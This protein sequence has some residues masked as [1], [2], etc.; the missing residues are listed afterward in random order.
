M[1]SPSLATSTTSAQ[2]HLAD[3]PTAALS[4]F[5]RSRSSYIE[6][7]HDLDFAV[8]SLV[9]D[10]SFDSESW[11]LERLQH[12]NQQLW[13]LAS[14][15]DVEYRCPGIG[16]MYASWYHLR[17][18]RGAFEILRPRLAATGPITVL[19]LGCGTGAVAWAL[20]M[21]GLPVRY[22]GVD[23]SAP[24][25]AWAKGLW[26]TF[27][28]TLP[29]CDTVEVNWIEGDAISLVLDGSLG[30]EADVAVMP[31]LVDRSF[32][33]R[34]RSRG[35]AWRSCLEHMGVADVISW[36][37]ADKLAISLDLMK[38]TMGSAGLPAHPCSGYRFDPP[39]PLL[40]E[41]RLELTARLGLTLRDKQP[42]GVGIRDTFGHHFLVARKPR[43]RNS[44]SVVA[45]RLAL[46]PPQLRAT[47][48]AIGF[49]GANALTMA[50]P[51]T[52]GQLESIHRHLG[53][54][55]KLKEYAR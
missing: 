34:L 17:R 46:R 48:E 9:T 23:A 16:R 7:H 26:D 43:P 44:L 21:L 4:G 18:V 50:S 25:L 29:E 12:A 45:R 55:F 53:R 24:M 41:A 51:L 36:T 8:A 10:D 5:I 14:G 3:R 31:F 27:R 19:D 42:V 49:E 20:G 11:S 2:K 30:E 15:G 33:R 38:Q 6:F 54:K 22:I 37:T 47:C 1:P 39:C 13:S 35:D 32:I 52:I 28:D 40:H